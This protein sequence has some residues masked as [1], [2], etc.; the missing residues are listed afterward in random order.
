MKIIIAGCA[1]RMGKALLLAALEEQKAGRL[2][3]VGGTVNP[4]SP[5]IGKDL[6]K[7]IGL[8]E[9]SGIRVCSDLAPL[10]VSADAVIDFT[11]PS[12][13]CLVAKI[14][15][16]YNLIHICGTTGFSATEQFH[17]EREALKHPLLYSANMS[18][19]V[20]ILV[21]QAQ[22]IAQQLPSYDVDILDRHHCNKID[23][24]SGTSIMLGE[25]I[26]EARGI[27][28]RRYSPIEAAGKRPDDVIGFAS[29]RAG[30]MVGT[31]DVTFINDGESITISHQ[32]FNRSIYAHGAFKACYWMKDKPAGKVYS[33]L[34]I[35]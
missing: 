27:E 6:Y 11:T 3:L 26:A 10:A 15:S 28:L 9:K 30:G 17:L 21:K 24:P 12:Y 14:C 8:E 7:V 5:F 32:S 2:T 29:L 35:I 19:G 4:E 16:Q 31:H 13:S 18:V 1:G 34:D 22:N 33:M 25:A 23:A 20:A